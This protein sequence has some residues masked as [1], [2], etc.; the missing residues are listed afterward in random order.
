M[1]LKNFLTASGSRHF[2]D[3][4]ETV[5]WSDLRDHIARL[6][7]AVVTGYLTDHVTEVWIDFTYRNQSFTVN[8]QWGD[9]WFFVDQPD[10]PDAILAEVAEH[11]ASITGWEYC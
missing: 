8:N 3:L 7:G 11:C 1:Q 6:P 5:E 9:Y 4:P 2:L 10:C